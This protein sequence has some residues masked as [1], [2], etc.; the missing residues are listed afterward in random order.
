[1]ELVENVV[2]PRSV[3]N[4]LQVARLIVARPKRR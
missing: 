4:S 3:D 2:V 1:M